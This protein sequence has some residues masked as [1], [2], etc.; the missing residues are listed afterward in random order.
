MQ[1]DNQDQRDQA[2]LCDEIIEQYEKMEKRFF[3][4]AE[5]SPVGVFRTDEFG[6]LLYVNDAFTSITGYNHI[7]TLGNDLTNFIHYYDRD[8]VSRKWKKAIETRTDFSDR[9]RIRNNSDKITWVIGQAKPEI[10]EDGAFLGFIGTVYDITEHVDKEISFRHRAFHDDLTGLPNRSLAVE[11]LSVE[12]NRAVENRTSVAVISIDLDDFKSIND[13]FG[14]S[15]GD[16]L[17]IELSGRIVKSVDGR[18]IVARV[19]GDEFLIV[20]TDLSEPDDAY[21]IAL[22]IK[23]EIIK[24]IQINGITFFQTCSQGI[25]IFPESGTTVDDLIRAADYAMYSAKKA[26]K[27]NIRFYSRKIEMYLREKR[28]IENMLRGDLD[29]NVFS[30]H[31]QGIYNTQSSLP[32]SYEALIRWNGRQVSPEIFIPIAEEAGLI[33]RVTEQTIRM[34]CTDRT[35]YPY[36]KN[37]RIAINLSPDILQNEDIDD[38]LNSY[39]RE[40]GCELDLLDIEITENALMKDFDRVVKSLKKLKSVGVNIAI[41]DFGT[42]FSSLSYLK[43]LPVDSIK[44]DKSFLAGVPEKEENNAIIRAVIVMGHSLNMTIIAEGVEKQDQ[45]DLLKNLGCDYVQGFLLDVPRPVY[46]MTLRHS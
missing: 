16:K 41:D 20:L 25:S 30:M 38:L 46:E 28:S 32:G 22:S 21:H 37:K 11:E 35:N 7:E 19:S 24:K 17:L 13:V 4:L 18:G 10:G 5:L 6:G 45:F 31:Y 3:A 9:F 2:G 12:I 14:H 40:Y 34:I 26:G 36:L 8:S 23:E 33:K 39:T 15:T 42:G 27:N 1:I 29:K 43:R 44:I